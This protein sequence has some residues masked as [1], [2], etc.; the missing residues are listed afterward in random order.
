MEKRTDWVQWAWFRILDDPFEYRLQKEAPG[1]APC[2]CLLNAVGLP[3]HTLACKGRRNDT[4]ESHG[5]RRKDHAH[6]SRATS[7]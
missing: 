4:Q 7:E 5:P 6:R 1:S 3:D 2:G